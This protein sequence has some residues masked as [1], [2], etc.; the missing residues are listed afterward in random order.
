MKRKKAGH[1]K[2]AAKNGPVAGEHRGDFMSA[3]TRS[4]LMSR[5]KGQNT[6][7]E[8]A[9][10]KLLLGVAIDF[11]RHDRSLPGKPDFVLRKERI[12]IF[13]DGDFWHGW[14]FPLWER[15]LNE[16]WRDKISANRAR[17]Q[18]NFAKLRRIGWKVIRI[19]EHQLES[20]LDRCLER[21]LL[22]LRPSKPPAA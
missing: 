13:V 11:E 2:W 5:I 4:R 1:R 7:P 22:C 8:L 10:E 6:G 20:S 21:I 15:K 12:A 9:M 17:D 14:R 18:R 16:K 19:W 3:E